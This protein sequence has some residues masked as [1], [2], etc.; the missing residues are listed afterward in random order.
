[1]CLIDDARRPKLPS[2]DLLLDVLKRYARTLAGRFD[3]AEVLDELIG[4]VVEVLGASAA[5]VSLDAGDGEL[6]FANASTAEARRLEAAQEATQHGPCVESF[7]RREP[8]VVSNHEGLDKWPEFSK[9]AREV[10]VVAVA[11]IP[12]ILDEKT[13]GA[14]NIYDTRPREWTTEDIAI[15]SVFA[16]IATSYVLHATQLLEARQINEQL[17]KALDSRVL[18][19]QAKG[20]IAGERG[21]SVDASFEILRRHA[22]NNNVTL[23][24]V[25]DAV[26]H[27]GLRP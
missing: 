4:H 12:L 15:A 21:I 25:A 1:M 8:V 5:G 6:R 26:V 18:V 16:D 3:A 23:R 10:G 17:Q 27:L 14:L 11:G 7:R 20:L 9:V 24:S 2:N 19:E 13:L 22:R